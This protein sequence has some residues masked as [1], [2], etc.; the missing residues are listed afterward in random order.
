MYLSID[1]GEIN[2]A[3]AIIEDFVEQHNGV[4]EEEEKAI[5]RGSLRNLTYQKMKDG[6]SAL[7]YYCVGFISRNLAFRLWNKLNDV[8]EKCS[9]IQLNFKVSKKKLWH[10][11]E[12]I[13]QIDLDRH[14]MQ[15]TIPAL[16]MEG[17][18]LRDR[19]ELEE[20]LFDR[21]SSERHFRARDLCLGSQPCM[22]IQRCRQSQRIR[23]QF[24]R[25][26]RVL[27]CIGRHSQ[28]PELLA[29]FAEE[30]N[31]YLVYEYTPG[32]ALT[33]L[34][35]E[36]WQESEVESLLRGLLA[37]LEFIQQSNITHRNLNP[38]NIIQSGNK[39]ILTDFATVKEVEHSENSVSYSTLDQGMKGYMPA[40]Q[41]T[42]MATFASD[43]YAIGKIAIHALT[44]RHPCR[45]RINP[46]TGNLVWRNQARVSDRFANII[47]R[48]V[49]YHFGD[50]YQ[51]AREMLEILKEMSPT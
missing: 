51:S 12:Q 2:R 45:L 4:L 36:P 34:L 7:K 48:A 49:C 18:I 26:G 22:V 29:Y 14:S 32:T 47:D 44:G 8:A 27:T 16:N 25:E 37:V 43:I 33:E 19:Y 35:G 50:R 15:I 21:D 31:L 13:N 9:S 28:I 41:Y 42:G 39:W 20:H 10:F 1:N 24:A 46:Q 30:R 23:Q 6:E 40:E 11:I 3:I 17:V 38:D 5:I